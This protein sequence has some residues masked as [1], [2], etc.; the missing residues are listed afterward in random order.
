MVAVALA[1]EILCSLRKLNF[2]QLAAVWPGILTFVADWLS[3]GE[4]I[5]DLVG[6]TKIVGGAIG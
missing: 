5:G 4:S 1:F 3:I 6:A 2:L